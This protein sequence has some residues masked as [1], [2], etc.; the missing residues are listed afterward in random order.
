[1]EKSVSYSGY[2]FK[3][4]FQRTSIS[5]FLVGDRTLDLASRR[6]PAISALDHFGTNNL[7]GN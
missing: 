4:C 2:A 1:M 7:A 5:L 3:P 6:V